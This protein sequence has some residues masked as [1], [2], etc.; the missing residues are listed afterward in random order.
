LLRDVREDTW[1]GE[2][3]SCPSLANPA[4]I[5]LGSSVNEVCGSP[6]PASA[7]PVTSAAAALAVP[8]LVL[9]LARM[10]VPED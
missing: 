2:G 1:P 10:T 6:E 5:T 9:V 4:M 8:D 3:T 7:L